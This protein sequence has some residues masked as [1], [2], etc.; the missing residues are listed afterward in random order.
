MNKESLMKIIKTG[1]PEQRM[2]W[3]EV[4]APNRPDSDGEYMTAETIKKMAY[5]FVRQGK[6]KMVD[7]NHG[8]ETTPGVEIVESFI[9]R[10]GDPDFIP[11]SWVVGVHIPSDEIWD[12]V[13]KGEINGFS[14]EAIVG[15]E[16]RE[17]EIEVPDVVSGTTTKSENHVHKFYVT[18]DP[19]TQELKGGRTDVVN[20]HMHVIKAGTKTEDAQG[21]SHRFSAVDSLQIS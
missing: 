17:V 1:E 9:A 21:H 13:K 5:D 7:I 8:N 19:T 2:V 14:V 6:T 4:Y 11:G 15:K 3:A 20:G 16:D 10:K 18:Y 12:M